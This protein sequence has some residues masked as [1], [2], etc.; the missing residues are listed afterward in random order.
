MNEELVDDSTERL[1]PTPFEKIRVVEGRK[2][3]R[4]EFRQR[5]VELE[6]AARQESAPRIYE[7]FGRL[8]I[9]FSPIA[10]HSVASV[11]GLPPESETRDSSTLAESSKTGN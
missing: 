3:D 6:E 4:D 11:N 9:G 2:F 8:N 10:A 1:A 7:V 5:L